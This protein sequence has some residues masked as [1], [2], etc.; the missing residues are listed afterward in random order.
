MAR[1]AGAFAKISVMMM[2]EKI[3]TRMRFAKKEVNLVK[4][5]T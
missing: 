3:I 1:T 5:F 2:E 4:R